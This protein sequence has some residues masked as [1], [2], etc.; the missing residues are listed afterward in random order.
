MDRNRDKFQD[1]MRLR[2]EK[3]KSP[4]DSK[5]NY[6]KSLL[7]SLPS[8]VFEI[9]ENGNFIYLNRTGFEK[10]GLSEDDENREINLFHFIE[11]NEEKIKNKLN[12]ILCGEKEGRIDL[13]MVMKSKKSF[14]AVLH[15]ISVSGCG[16]A[17]RFRGIAEDITRLKSIEKE[18]TL[19]IRKLEE[20]SANI[21]TLRGLL[22]ICSHCKRIRDKKGRWRPLEEYI[23]EHTEAEFSHSLCPHCLR[24]LYSD[25]FEQQTEIDFSEQE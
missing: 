9:D 14:Y 7:D 4:A 1:E 25:L 24:V 20:A 19:L 21:K 11:E 10:L 2:E 13:R 6:Y 17:V 3:D 5:E 12:R 18:Q 15:V 8:L 23:G 16:Q 22:P